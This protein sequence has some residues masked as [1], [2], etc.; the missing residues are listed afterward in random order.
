MVTDRGASAQ[1]I[2]EAASAS[3]GFQA[4]WG[5]DAVYWTEQTETMVK[6]L[7]ETQKQMWKNWFALMPASLPRRLFIRMSPTR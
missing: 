5:G 1:E 2:V 7:A 6:A 4:Y 3:G